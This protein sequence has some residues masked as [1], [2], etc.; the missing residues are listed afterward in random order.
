MSCYYCKSWQESDCEGEEFCE[1]P[2]CRWHGVCPNCD[3]RPEE[4]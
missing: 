3:R 4:E 2:L 1:G